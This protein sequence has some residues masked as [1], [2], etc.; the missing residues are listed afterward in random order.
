MR[1]ASES[2]SPVIRT[3]FYEFPDDEK[4]WEVE[5]HYMFGDKYLCAPIF[6]FGQRERTVYLPKLSRWAQLIIGDEE[7]VTDGVFEGV[8]PSQSPVLSI[9]FL[10]LLG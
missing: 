3:M 4:C 9:C 5:T 1:D 2:G 8:R 6:E 7:D 10:S